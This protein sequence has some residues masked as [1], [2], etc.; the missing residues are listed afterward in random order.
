[1]F[2][3]DDRSFHTHESARSESWKLQ[4]VRTLS[5]HFFK[6][7]IYWWK[8]CP[9]QGHRLLS[10][11]HHRQYA[12][13]HS[14]WFAVRKSLFDFTHQWASPDWPYFRS[15]SETQP[16]CWLIGQNKSDIKTLARL[17]HSSNNR[18][19][20][21]TTALTCAV[22]SIKMH[23]NLHRT[24]NLNS[25]HHLYQ[26]LNM[27]ELCNMYQA[28]GIYWSCV[29]LAH[30]PTIIVIRTFRGDKLKIGGHTAKSLLQNV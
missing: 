25:S 14:V 28:G 1:M 8:C 17:G 21:V 6:I 5:F 19:N 29:G 20:T 23:A 18:G 16:W 13:A 2:P 30:R 12:V 10:I 24:I 22:I 7:I 9:G 11:W 26:H 15:V 3:S 27:Q 4:H